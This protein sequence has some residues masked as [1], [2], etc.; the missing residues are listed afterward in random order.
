MEED[1]ET[2]D[3]EPPDSTFTR[4]YKRQDLIPLLSLNSLNRP[5]RQED[6][7]SPCSIASSDQSGL[8]SHLVTP[9]ERRLSHYDTPSLPF[10]DQ[11][12]MEHQAIHINPF[13]LG[14]PSDILK[15]NLPL[16]PLSSSPIVSADGACFMDAFIPTARSIFKKKSHLQGFY[17]GLCWVQGSVLPIQFSGISYRQDEYDH[18]ADVWPYEGMLGDDEDLS[19]CSYKLEEQDNVACLDCRPSRMSVYDADGTKQG[20]EGHHYSVQ[21]IVSELGSLEST[22]LKSFLSR[23]IGNVCSETPLMILRLSPT[24]HRWLNPVQKTETCQPVSMIHLVKASSKVFEA[25]LSGNEQVIEWSASVT[26]R[27]QRFC[28]DRKKKNTDLSDHAT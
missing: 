17:L 19:P 4:R 7:S 20:V 13:F 1:D 15:E 18:Q 5:D 8:D 21:I 11:A 16:S 14:T 6:H 22:R 26:W 3:G 28:T 12:G 23:S 25:V 2:D 27:I 10:T 24:P 9:G